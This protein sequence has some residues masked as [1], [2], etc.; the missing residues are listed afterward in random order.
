MKTCSLNGPWQFRQA[1]KKDWFSATVPGSVFSDLLAQGLIPDPFY[2]E[3]EKLVGWVSDVDWEYQRT[4][5]VDPALL[6]EDCIELVCAGLDTIAEVEL[7]GQAIGSTQNIFR[8]YRLD[9]KSWLKPAG[10]R[11]TV[12][13][14]SPTGYIAAQQGVRNLPPGVHSKAAHIRKVQSHFGWDWGPVLPGAGIWKEISIQA[15]SQ[16]RLLDVRLEQTHASGEV[17]LAAEVDCEAFSE[18]PLTLDLA[19]T[20]PDGAVFHQAAAV[21]GRHGRVAGQIRQPQLWWPNGLGTQPLYTV[22]VSLVSRGEIL[23][24]RSYTAGLR[25]LELRRRPDE[26]GESFTFVVNDV[27][28][29]AKGANWIPA[30][31]IITRLTPERLE[32]LIRSSAE[33]NMNMLRVWGGGYYESDAFYDLCDHY[34]ILVWQD[35]GFACAPY[36]LGDEDY[37][38]NVHAEVVENVRRLRHHASLALW[39][40]NNEIESMWDR[41]KDHSALTAAY[42]DFFHKRLPEWVAAEDPDHAYWPSSPSSG[43]FMDDT[44]GDTRGD[45]HLWEVWHRLEPFTYYRTRPTRFC[46]EFG[47]ESLPSLEAIATFAKPEEFSISSKVM[48]HHQRSLE[49]NAR[50]LF[51]LSERF[52]LPAD[53]SDLVYLTQVSQAECIRMGVEHWRRNRPRCGGALYWQLN[54]CWPVSSWAGIDYTGQWK[55]LQY[56][57]RRFYA[58]LSLSLEDIGSRVGV[59]VCNDLPEPW[60]GEL[61]WSLET[62]AGE[63]IEMG[64]DPLDA[65]GL[66]ATQVRE[67]DFG[68]QVRSHGASDLAFVAELWQAGELV[69]RQALQ[70]APEKRL[71]LP[72]PGLKV[73]LAASGQTLT[74]TLTTQNLARFVRLA[75]PDMGIIFSDNYFDL[76]GGRQKTVTCPLP[77]G[78]TLEQARQALQVRSLADVQPAGSLFADWLVHFGYAARLHNVINRLMLRLAR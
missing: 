35:F 17:T 13:L 56:A 73:D 77:Q 9:V 59:F 39:C 55:A 46:S 48:L 18:S 11:L 34:G 63:V 50:M 68:R 27:P 41:W 44:N 19:V 32:H 25:T 2:G 22:A 69:A 37:R 78:W 66:V 54:D 8:S 21:A 49:G 45:T 58:P 3:N 15:F 40:G 67:F 12:R 5:D 47:M 60:Q 6:G 70:F 57:A 10:N 20:A 75:F 1:G 26:W 23:D 42:V 31:S 64:I 53:F 38:E 14:K 51:Y 74:V 43:D 28:I 76:P 52:R 36:P 7:N 4:F 71:E 16:A 61:R 29:F 72:E 33:A 65:A 62:F 24:R 30:N